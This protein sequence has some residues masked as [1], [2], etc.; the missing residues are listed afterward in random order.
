[1]NFHTGVGVMDSD[2]RKFS[3]DVVNC[4]AKF[5]ILTSE[6]IDRYVATE[7]P[8]DCAGSFKCEALGISLFEAIVTNDPI[9]LI[10]L[11]LISLVSLLFERGLDGLNCHPAQ[12]SRAN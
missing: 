3:V 6:Q 5:R 1:M 9:A 12:S 4:Q 2:T 8:T 11:P 7:S 10:D